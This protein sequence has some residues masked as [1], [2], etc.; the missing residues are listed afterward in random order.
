MTESMLWWIAAGVVLGA[1]LL[2]GTVYLLLLSVGMVTAGA[3]AH[4]GASFAVQMLVCAMVGGASMV[5]WRWRSRSKAA[6]PG[7]AAGFDLDIGQR[8]PVTHWT[9]D[10][11]TT[12]HYRGASWQARWQGSTPPPGPGEYAIVAIDGARLVL[13]VIAPHDHPV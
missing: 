3:A 11:L 8:V 9:H 4:L 6:A 12:V 10:S 5:L 7:G 13:G 1:E 2:T